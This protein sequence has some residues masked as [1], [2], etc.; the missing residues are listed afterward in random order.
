MLV[1]EDDEAL[2]LAL[3]VYLSGEEVIGTVRTAAVG[4]RGLELARTLHPDVIV[5]DSTM[6]GLSGD[7]LGEQ[8]RG[9]CPESTIVSFSGASQS[10]QWADERII[11]G[12][13][14]SFERLV[15]VVSG[16]E[17]EPPPPVRQ[18]RRAQQQR[19]RVHDLRN[20]MTPITGYAS[21]LMNA[22]DTLGPD[23]LRKIGDR[24]ARATGRAARLIDEL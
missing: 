13:R 4:D 5:T 11:K 20:A 1:I 16:A 12:E 23:D 8:L 15:E 7:G 24:V 10:A 6:P 21:L 9:A 22:A 3:E 17:V 19:R 2:R 14:D 18:E